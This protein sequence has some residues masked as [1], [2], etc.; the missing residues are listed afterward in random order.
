L[1]IFNLKQYYIEEELSAV[2]NRL[3]SAATS[4]EVVNIETLF[5]CMTFDVIG[6]VCLGHKFGAISDPK[7]KL[8]AAWSKTAEYFMFGFAT[9]M[10]P[11]WKI[12]KTKYVKELEENVAFLEGIFEDLIQKK[13][14]AELD[15]EDDSLLALMIRANKKNPNTYS[16]KD[17]LL[18][19]M[20]FLFAGHVRMSSYL[21][22]KKDTTRN[23][24]EWIFYYLC[25]HPEVEAKL[26]QEIEENIG[27]RQVTAE[28]LEKLVYLNCVVKETLRL[29]P[30]SNFFYYL[31]I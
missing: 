27:S 14:A 28:E 13:L 9:S 17:Y 18:H 11:Y 7:A 22:T 23:G 4:S 3:E 5:A 29:K 19:V 10:F 20:N 30:R 8:T 1:Q 15:E 6:R 21:L 25:C 31:N 2:C 16:N 24:I 26:L 12:Y